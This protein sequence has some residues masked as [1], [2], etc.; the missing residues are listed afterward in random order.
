M[1]VSLFDDEVESI[2]LFDPLTGEIFD[3]IKRFTIYPK[4]HYVTTR[5]T[6]VRAIE[7]IKSELRD[8]VDFCERTKASRSATY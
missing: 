2:S 1:R 5:D 8:R 6:T 7:T 4:S 3:K